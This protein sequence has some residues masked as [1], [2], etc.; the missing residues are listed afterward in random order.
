M[1][2]DD[3]LLFREV[4]ALDELVEVAVEPQQVAGGPHR[5]RSQLAD[6]RELRIEQHPQLVAQCGDPPPFAAEIVLT[7][8][9]QLI[10]G[11][12]PAPDELRVEPIG[13]QGTR[14]QLFEWRNPQLPRHRARHVQHAF[15]GLDALVMVGN[16]QLL[17]QEHSIKRVHA[18]KHQKLVQL[19]RRMGQR[20]LIR[21]WLQL[22]RCLLHRRRAGCFF[23]VGPRFRLC[24]L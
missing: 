14:G 9:L 22:R 16:A 19:E 1:P 2:K 7:S 13:G 23:Q 3:A 10:G 17:N 24:L 15:Q 5:T 4:S 12:Q 18:A 21:Y 8:R 20:R 6:V 11:H